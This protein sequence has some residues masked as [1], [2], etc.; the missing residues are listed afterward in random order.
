MEHGLNDIV[1]Y[2]QKHIAHR[3][4]CYNFSLVP[5]KPLGRPH[6][7]NSFVEKITID[8]EL[9]CQN[10][11]ECRQICHI[12]DRWNAF[13]WITVGPIDFFYSETRPFSPNEAI[14]DNLNL[15][16]IYTSMYNYGDGVS[17]FIWQDVKTEIDSNLTSGT[18]VI[19]CSSP[20]NSTT[21]M[22]YIPDS[23]VHGTNMGPTWGQ[24]DPGGPHVGHM[25][26]TIWDDIITRDANS[27]P[28]AEIWEFSQ[29]RNVTLSMPSSSLR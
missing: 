20:W 10:S 1:F 24:Q 6:L 25:N 17:I 28:W 12:S 21:R 5:D 23:K 3:T 4:G 13:K 8:A 19:I 16:L 15:V 26:F 11:P 2:I 29:S 18:H 9:I 22:G 14:N 7:W 27:E